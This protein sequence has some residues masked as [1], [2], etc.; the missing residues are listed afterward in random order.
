VLFPAA[1]RVGAGGE[2][3]GVDL[4]DAMAHAQQC[5]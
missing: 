2:V 5:H 1:E 3:I 4:A